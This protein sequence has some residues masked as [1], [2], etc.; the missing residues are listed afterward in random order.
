MSNQANNTEPTEYSEDIEI[1]ADLGLNVTEAKIF[2]ALSELET[3]T[4][5]TISNKSGVAR[6]FVYQ[7]MPRLLNKGLI[8][9]IMTKPKKFKSL[10]LK[11]AY[12]IL[13]RRKK[14]ENKKL[15]SKAMKALRKH[16]NKSRSQ[17]IADSQLSLVPSLEAPIISHEFQNAQKKIDITFLPEKF[18]QWSQYYDELKVNDVIK[19]KVKIRV[20]TQQSLVEIMAAYPGS[21]NGSLRSKLKTVDFK[22]VRTPFSVEMMIFDDKTLFLS[23]EKASDITQI[24]WL[25]T[26]KP[27]LLE[28]AKVYFE[29]L[30]KCGT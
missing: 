7:V 9:E 25:R 2:V 28:M 26:N 4:V 21:F 24:V 22:H 27:S 29:Q 5:G 18:V 20:I 1:L 30:W 17:M 16:E 10:S 8:E 23:T 19:R 11:E 15:Y 6:E 12:L 3:A 13:L 14:E